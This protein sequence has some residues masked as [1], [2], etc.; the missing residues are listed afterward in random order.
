MSRVLACLV[1][2]GCSSMYAD[3]AERL[4]KPPIKNPPKLE[5]VAQVDF[6]YVDTCTFDFHA[7]K[8]TV[9][10]DHAVGHALT[11]EA[12]ATMDGAKGKDTKAYNSV[13]D[14]I[15]KYGNA[16][17]KDPYDAETTLKLALAYDRMYRKGCA[18]A[19]LKRLAALDANPKF[20]AASQI[21]QVVDN[22]SMFKA[23]RNEAKN[24][25]GR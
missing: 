11:V 14:A 13:R 18:L 19:M 17:R 9:R 8:M 6:K 16:L 4:A 3:K 20:G 10:A 7:N 24:A 2:A 22:D 5:A 25:V 15:D 1:L 12:D 21:G 23:Y